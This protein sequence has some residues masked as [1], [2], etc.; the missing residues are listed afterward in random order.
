MSCTLAFTI[1]EV[2]FFSNSIRKSGKN[3]KNDKDALHC[4]Q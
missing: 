2:S 4:V 1:N 3:S